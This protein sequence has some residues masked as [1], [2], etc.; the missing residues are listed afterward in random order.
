M[1]TQPLRV[2]IVEDS[3][4]FARLLQIILAEAITAQFE[5]ICV[6]RSGEAI[7]QLAERPFDVILLDLILPDSQGLDT[8]T[9]M[10]DHAGDVPIVVMT[11]LDDETLG[12]KAVQLGAQDYIV[13]SK[14][15]RRLLAPA[16]RYAIERKRAEVELRR[17]MEEAEAASR[18]KSAFLARMSHEL[19]T[20]LTAIIG[21]S[22]VLQQHPQRANDSVLRPALGQICGAGKRLLALI[23]DVLDYSRLESG[24]LELCPELLPLPP[25]LSAVAAAVQA[26]VEQN[27]NT[28]TVNYPDDLAPVY[29]DPDRLRQ[30]L[31]HLVSNAAKFTQEGQTTLSAFPEAVDPTADRPTAQEGWICVRVTDTGIGMAPEQVQALFQPFN[32]ADTSDTREYGGAGLGLALSRRLCQLMGCDISVESVPGQGSTFTMRLPAA[33]SQ[34]AGR[35]DEV[36]GIPQGDHAPGTPTVLVVDDDPAALEAISAY[37]TKAGFDTESAASGED[38]LRL[39]QDLRP[40][41]ITLDVLLP[42]MDGLAVL[43]ALKADPE[44]APIP[45]LM[46]TIVGNQN[47]ALAL[48]AAE[49]LTKPISGERLVE[50]LRK[51]LGL[52]FG[53]A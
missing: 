32:Q 14:L 17:A 22:E 1:H 44:L 51:H 3:L 34:A 24:S 36:P 8:L 5:M 31:F 27:G 4:V 33:E 43:A 49:F 13:K 52:S 7:K 23:N 26:Q 6:E 50:A 53:K 10:H 20:P 30:V 40:D 28:L 48:G 39:A 15:D 9:R 47:V 11:D 35:P 25:L 46:V 2:L 42:Q 21:Y 37:L 29:A 18:A 38:G 45:V 19:R 41:A 16:I 12:V